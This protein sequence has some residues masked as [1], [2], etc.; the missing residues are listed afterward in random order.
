MSACSGRID[1]YGI[2][3][4]IMPKVKKENAKKVEVAL[5]GYNLRI[6]RFLISDLCLR[7]HMNTLE[8]GKN[9]IKYKIKT[10]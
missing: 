2:Y 9:E 5:L 8:H 6:R 3:D 4:H 7:V 1:S 10:M